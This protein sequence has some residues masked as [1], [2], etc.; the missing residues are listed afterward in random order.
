MKRALTLFICWPIFL[1]L[2]LVGT[3][4]VHAGVSA[5]ELH[6]VGGPTTLSTAA[7]PSTEPSFSWAGW[8]PATCMP[9]AC[10]CERVRDGAIRQPVNTWSNLAFFLSGL[11]VVAFG[12]LDRL[13]GSRSGRLNPMRAHFVYPAVLGVA[14]ALIGL[15]STIYHSSMTFV[16]QSMDVISIYLLLG[17][18]LVYNLSRA[19][20][21]AMSGRV[22]VALYL[23]LNAG[24][25]LMAV[26]WPVSRRYIFVALI[27]AI[28]ATEF[29]I[30]R[31]RRPRMSQPLFYAALGSL[32]LACF[33]WILDVTRVICWPDS[34]FQ[35]HALWHVLTATAAGLVYFY[36]RSE[37]AVNGQTIGGLPTRLNH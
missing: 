5:A 15:G 10:F 25:A 37:N 18:M 36:F 1:V 23:L 14:T 24:L 21:E 11:A 3:T 34:W 26:R 29:V 2:L 17:F 28:L 30:R 9:D 7:S 32:A 33:A 19:R 6:P 31:T 27:L 16:G 4:V 13:V 8:R 12:G 35:A 20:A 22:F